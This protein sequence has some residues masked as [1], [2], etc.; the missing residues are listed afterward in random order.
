MQVFRIDLIQFP[1]TKEIT[2]LCRRYLGTDFSGVYCQYN[3]VLPETQYP[4]R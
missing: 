2:K 3:I 4:K 1:G